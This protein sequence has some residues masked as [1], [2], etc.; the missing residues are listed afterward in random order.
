MKKTACKISRDTVPLKVRKKRKKE[1]R[2]KGCN[3][4]RKRRRCGS[5]EP[6]AESEFD[7]CGNQCMEHGSVGRWGQFQ[8]R[9]PGS[10]VSLCRIISDQLTP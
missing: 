7:V 1:S 8:G 2:N 10:E 9:Q 5:D 4:L 3:I 6:D